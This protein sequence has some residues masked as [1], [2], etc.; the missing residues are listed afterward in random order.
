MDPDVADLLGVTSGGG[1]AR[2][3][4]VPDHR[5]QR[6]RM[7]ELDEQARALAASSGVGYKAAMVALQRQERTG[8]RV[9]AAVVAATNAFGGALIQAMNSATTAIAG[10][11]KTLSQLL[12]LGP[13]RPPA[14]R[15]V[16][17]VVALLAI[18][19]H[20]ACPR[21]RSD[22]PGG[23]CPAPAAT[24]ILGPPPLMAVVLRAPQDGKRR[25]FGAV[26]SRWRTDPFG[27]DRRAYACRPWPRM[28]TT[29]S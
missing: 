20:P 26:A 14:H 10:F 28:V 9:S 11:G 23:L 21:C 13:P 19:H 18:R 25:S 12:G 29:P 27:A 15:E 16:A 24:R 6:A 4:V 17:A 8:D 2:F 1:D 22:G 5:V 7:G 3:Q